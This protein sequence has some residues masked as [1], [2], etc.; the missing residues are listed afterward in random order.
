MLKEV[1]VGI[2]NDR[3]VIRY[4]NYVVFMCIYVFLSGFV[5]VE[6][7]LAEI[8]FTVALPFLILGLKTNRSI[9]FAFSALFLPMLLSALIGLISFGFLDFRFIITDTYLFVF[10][11]VLASYAK[12]LTKS[13]YQERFLD[14]LMIPWSLAGA[15]NII[16]GGFGYLTGRVNLFGSEILKYDRL[17]GFFKDPNVLG[18]FLVPVSAYFLMQFLKAR[19]NELLNFAFFLFFSFGIL[20]TFSR[21]AWLNYAVTTILLIGTAL[22]NR[23]T[24]SKALSLLVIIVPG[25]FVFWYFADKIDLLGTNLRDFILTRLTL[26]HYDSDRF[27]AQRKFVDILSSANAFFG[28]GPGN[29]ELYSRI[30][31]HSLY[32][33]YIGERGLFGVSLFVVF[34]ALVLREVFNSRD[35]NF[36]LLVL[37]GQLVNS[38]FIDSLHW[39][40]LWLLITLAFLG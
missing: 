29:Y 37:L 21:A 20:L 14:R 40:H 33:R 31:T 10:F 28:I 36:I 6:P 34:W 35:K 18:P 1:S 39:R 25:L 8:W 12:S 3:E 16:A 11:F 13:P 23:S 22:L 7:S 32:A 30:S 24:R 15:V 17:T 27:E 2:P 5:F 19:R 26:Q 38:V 9:I 4:R